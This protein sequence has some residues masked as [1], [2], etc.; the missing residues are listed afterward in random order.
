MKK[1]SDQLRDAGYR[2]MFTVHQPPFRAGRTP[3]PI[4]MTPKGEQTPKRPVR[5]IAVPSGAFC[6]GTQGR[7]R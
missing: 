3:A 4:K 2:I 1:E 7:T 6:K 5:C